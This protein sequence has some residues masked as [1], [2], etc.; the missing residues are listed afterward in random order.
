[1]TRRD[2]TLLLAALLFAGCAGDAVDVAPG[3]AARTT[4]ALSGPCPTDPTAPAEF[5]GEIDGFSVEIT[6]P[7]INSA[8][9][10]AGGTDSLRI[11]EIPAGD[12]RTIV[13][14]GELS[15]AKLWRGIRTGVTIAADQETSVNILLAKVADLT[16]A[17]NPQFEPLA[18]HTATVLQ[19]GRV[20]LT[21][22]ANN[23]RDCGANR[24][25]EASSFAELY[26][27]TLG[28]FTR[29]TGALN[30]NRMFHTATLLDDGRV[31]IAGGTSDAEI[32]AVDGTNPF[33]IRPTN[34]VS[35]VEVFDPT[36]GMFTSMGDDTVPRV[37]HAAVKMRD[38]R[39]LLSGGVPGVPGD[40]INSLHNAENTTTVCDVGTF[41]CSGFA[42]LNKAR[43]GHVSY[44]DDNGNV[45]VWG[46]SVDLAAT[47][48]LA[49]YHM[50]VMR[51][52]ST[53]FEMNEV[54]G[55]SNNRN[56]FFHGV[57]Q[58]H[59]TRVLSAGGLVRDETGTFTLASTST[60]ATKGPVYVHDTTAAQA[61]GGGLSTGGDAA[62]PWSLATLRFFAASAPLTGRRVLMS[63]GFTSLEFAPSS[64]VSLF[65]EGSLSV[66]PL[67][68]GGED[69][70]LREGRAGHRMSAIGDGT[71][72]ITGGLTGTVDARAPNGTGE[73]FGDPIAPEVGQ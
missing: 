56:L 5:T 8:I 36:T 20:L 57:T 27:P 64:G 41:S 51:T 31:L 53:V 24:C 14:F 72:V 73:V 1:M 58:Y 9:T 40:G 65:D 46:G 22:G 70:S 17:R 52:G 25:L 6:G 10:A 39:V 30:R 35:L 28:Q 43:A 48:G 71:V 12:N 55:M 34:V 45:I 38:G 13:L 7:G 68:V 16:C 19:D 33:P 42:T 32:V 18:F 21:G 59:P 67:S 61:P 2:H 60:D 63:G 26:D 4:Y 37:F 29:I 23:E 3:L 47:Q 54:A 11:E 49:G 69:R 15:G 44:I 62:N 50:E 66:G